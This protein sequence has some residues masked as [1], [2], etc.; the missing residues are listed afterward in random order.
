[1]NVFDY[2]GLAEQENEEQKDPKEGDPC[3]PCPDEEKCEISEKKILDDGSTVTHINAR[4]TYKLNCE[5]CCHI[6][7]HWWWT[8]TW[9]SGGNTG[10]KEQ[11]KLN[12]PFGGHNV[13]VDARIYYLSCELQGKK[14]VWVKPLYAMVDDVH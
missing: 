2:L 14:W 9:Y 4:L 3:T 12:D 7:E 6:L 11:D 8:C 13:I 5:E 10:W 1:M